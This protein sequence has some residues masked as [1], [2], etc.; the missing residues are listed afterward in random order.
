VLTGLSA[1]EKAIVVKTLD[2]K[3][4][5]PED[6]IRAAIIGWGG[7]SD[8]VSTLQG[9]PKE[10][11]DQ[12]E[13]DYPRKN[14]SSLTGDL[15]S[16]LRGKE[17]ADALRVLD[18]NLSADEKYIRA[19]DE[20]ASARSGFGAWASD[21]VFRSGTGVQADDTMQSYSQAVE[22]ASRVN[23]SVDPEKAEALRQ[24]IE[25]AIDNHKEA[26][27]AAAEYGADGVIAGAAIGSVIATGGADIPLVAALAVGGAAVKVGAKRAL[28]GEDYD[29]TAGQVAL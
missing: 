6:K 12:L 19:Q 28:M 11:L 15:M 25:K 18:S 8:I 10:K 21:H 9:V 16:K 22:Q 5:Q 4:L 23:Q 1:D 20:Y 29:M 7:A 24:Q 14:G 26:K 13:S 27:G 3:E 17:K 2:Q